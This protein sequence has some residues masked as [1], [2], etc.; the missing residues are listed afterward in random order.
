MCLIPSDDETIEFLR[1]CEH[2]WVKNKN[3]SLRIGSGII[4][5]VVM[6]IDAK[7]AEI[8]RLRSAIATK[9]AQ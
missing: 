5:H 8:A 2:A 4:A 6:I 9:E 7:D 3:G 1:E